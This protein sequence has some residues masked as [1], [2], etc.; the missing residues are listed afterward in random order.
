M[1]WLEKELK[2]GSLISRKMIRNK[3]KTLSNS[4]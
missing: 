2:S 3:A 4:R 1:N